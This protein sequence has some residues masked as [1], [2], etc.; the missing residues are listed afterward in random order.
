MGRACQSLGVYD[1]MIQVAASTHND[2][3]KYPDDIPTVAEGKKNR[4]IR[5]WVLGMYPEQS[6]PVA[7]YHYRY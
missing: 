2:S 6:L 7:E 5:V 4:L 3:H 1:Q